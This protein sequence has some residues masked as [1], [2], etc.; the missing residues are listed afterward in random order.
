MKTIGSIL[1]A[2]LDKDLI[3]EAGEHS[4]LHGGWQDIVMEAF[5]GKNR[6]LA[7]AAVAVDAEAVTNPDDYDFAGDAETMNL[8]NAGKL[9]YHSRVREL[10]RGRLVV[11]YDHP[12]WGQI[13]SFKERSLLAAARRHFPGLE[14]KTMSFVLKKD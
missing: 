4:R 2:F 10:D 7:E 12:G 5:V 1:E 11:E 14:I 3:A 8:V 13:L 6:A 9:R